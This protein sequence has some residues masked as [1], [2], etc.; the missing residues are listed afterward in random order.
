[1]AALILA[2]STGIAA[3][4]GNIFDT[5]R[6]GSP[7]DVEKMLAADKNLLNAR[8]ELGS[9]PLHM[10]ATN[11]NPE[12]AKLLVTKRANINARD[13]NGTTPLHL[14]AF[15]GKKGLVEFF[16]AHGADAYA[17]DFKGETP[18]D[19]AYHSLNGEIQTILVLWMLK[20]PEPAKKK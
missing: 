15:T 2:G 14:A 3:A 12:V 11:S 13:N 10:A 6:V 18:R 1:M 4:A 5:A 8:N 20:H 7:Q 9:T 17:T 16:L 19:K